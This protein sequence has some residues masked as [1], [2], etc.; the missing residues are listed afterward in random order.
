MAVSPVGMVSF[1]FVFESAKYKEDDKPMFSMVLVYRHLEM[2]EDQKALLVAMK[3]EAQKVARETFGCE[4]GGYCKD[5]GVCRSPFRKTEEKPKYYEPGGVFVKFKNKLRP[6]VVNRGMEPIAP[7]SGDFYAGCFAH[8]SYE[9]YA[10]DYMGN[11]GVAFSLGNVQKVGDG[12]P[13][14]G[15]RT[16]PEDDFQALPPIPGAPAPAAVPAVSAGP[17]AAEEEIPF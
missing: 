3:E 16:T 13:V 2:P 10:Y 15:K 12:E 7:E 8:A 11:K 5:G 4:L 6:N 17:I 1:P 14:G 9:A